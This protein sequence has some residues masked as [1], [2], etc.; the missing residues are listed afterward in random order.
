VFAVTE[1]Q[2]RSVQEIGWDT[3]FQAGQPTVL[4]DASAST[5]V[6][7]SAH[8]LPGDARCCV[9]AMDVV[10]F[11]WNGTRF[12]QSGIQTEPSEYA[13]RERKALPKTPPR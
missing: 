8:Y 1:G 5:L 6:I 13:K 4:F 7:R 2:L 11:R 9:S 12:A 10:T 3:H